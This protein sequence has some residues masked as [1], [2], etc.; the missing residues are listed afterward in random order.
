MRSYLLFLLVACNGYSPN[1]PAA[2][3][4]CGSGTPACP[5]GYNC[6]A[7]GSN[8][9]MVCVLPNMQ[10]PDAP[11]TCA[12]DSNL[13]PNDSIAQAYQTPIDGVM[14][15]TIPYTGLAICPAG[16]KDTY[17]INLAAQTSIE[18]VVTYDEGGA[19][20]QVTILSAA[21][22]PL[23]NGSP[24]GTQDQIRAYINMLNVGSYYV[25]VCGPASGGMLTNNYSLKINTGT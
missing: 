11:N 16:D 22:S 1:L 15:T 13:E 23:A 7:D 21:G 2:P 20:L 19:P 12:N 18:A 8:G 4:L 25:Q 17:A 10:V 14:R 6:M 3:F 5:E 24:T 9:R